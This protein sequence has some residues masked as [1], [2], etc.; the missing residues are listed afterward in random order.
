MKNKKGFDLL[1]AN[2]DEIEQKLGTTDLAWSRADEYKAS[3]IVYTLKGVSI[4]N[5]SDWPRMAKF[6]AEWSAKIADA[7]LPY[8]SELST[9]VELSA[10]KAEKNKALL[11]L[12]T[13]IKE[14]A[15]SRSA[16]GIMFVN[17]G[18]S[19]R[20]YT[21]FRT[22]FMDGIIPDAPGT[23]SGWNTEN[24][25]FYEILNKTGNS[26]FMQLAFS[27]KEMP[28]DQ[29]EITD[30]I[31]VY[32]PSKGDKPGWEYRVPFK[33]KS[34]IIENINDKDVVFKQLDKCFMEIKGFEDELKKIILT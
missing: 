16:Q 26:V 27:S 3:W 13:T 10:E 20:T 28:S 33:T 25:Y 14:W 32:Y 17:I 30:R 19:N 18:K 11:L 4:A 2:K 24:H 23:K 12:S 21:R 15:I 29:I 8:L 34:Y 5:E 7:F 31:N 1:F 6:H 9:D 22:V